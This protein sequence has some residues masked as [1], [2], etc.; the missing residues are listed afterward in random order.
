MTRALCICLIFMP[1]K[2]K[3]GFFENYGEHRWINV[4]F[5]W[6]LKCFYW[7]FTGVDL[8]VCDIPIKFVW[9]AI[10]KWDIWIQSI[11]LP[12]ASF[13]PIANHMNWLFIHFRLLPHHAISTFILEIFLEGIFW[14][15]SSKVTG[16]TFIFQVLILTWTRSGLP[17]TP[18]SNMWPRDPQVRKLN[19]EIEI[20]KW[21]IRF[22]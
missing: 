11:W 21:S 22:R 12:C 20:K 9:L 5:R 18:I 1:W 3:Q 13:L 7:M 4:K 2:E 17:S 10:Y 14:V 8:V 6:T 19:F 16:N 15:I